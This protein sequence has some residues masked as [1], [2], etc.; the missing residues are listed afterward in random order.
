MLFWPA[1]ILTSAGASLEITMQHRLRDPGR[2][3]TRVAAFTIFELLAVITLITVL[4]TLLVPA[5]R[6]ARETG[7]K[8]VCLSQLKQQATALNLYASANRHKAPPNLRWNPGAAGTEFLD[9]AAP[10]NAIAA[11]NAPSDP[12]WPGGP[13]YGG[14]GLLYEHKYFESHEAYFCPSHEEFLNGNCYRKSDCIERMRDVNLTIPCCS[15]T[16][17]Y[18]RSTVELT[19]NGSGN[20]PIRVSRDAGLGAIAEYYRAEGPEWPDGKFMHTIGFNLVYYNG[21]ARFFSTP[22]YAYDGNDYSGLG[23]E[24]FTGFKIADP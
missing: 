20:T 1:P 5:L 14:L 11:Q 2:S 16:T 17:Y 22:G 12:G 6:S 3:T 23:Q 4:L 13:R 7:R 19:Y 18:Y 24:P 21:S 15:I 8:T 9:Y 10:V